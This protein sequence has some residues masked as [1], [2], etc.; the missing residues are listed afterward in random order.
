MTPREKKSTPT[1]G[2]NQ[3][4]LNNNSDRQADHSALVFSLGPAGIRFTNPRTHA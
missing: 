4:M 1:N 3:T 2:I